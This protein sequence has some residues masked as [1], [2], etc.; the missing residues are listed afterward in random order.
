MTTTIPTER[1]DFASG[2]VRCAAWLTLPPGGGPHP[3]VVLIHGLGAT[4]DMALARYEQHFAAAGIATLAFDYRNTGLSD[5]VTRQH[6]SARDQ[7]ADVAAALT[8]LHER[9]DIDGTRIGLWGTSLGAMHA[10]RVAA[11]RDDVAATV[12]QCPIVHGPGAARRL[13]VLAALRLTPAIVDDVVRRATRRGRRYVP[14]VGPPGG[15][16]MVTVA[17]AEAGWQSTVDPGGHFD[18]RIGAADALG[19]VA[20]SSVRHARRIGAPL[21]VCVCDRE[22]LMDPRYAERVASR[23]P[24]GETRHYESDHFQIYHPPL[25]EHALADQTAFFQEHLRVRA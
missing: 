17:G 12:V 4:H 8:H 6:V 21:L 1:A 19:I 7:R 9:A 16:A 20:T 14:I 5:G 18:N 2:G 11:D 15:F 13:G 22:T 10:V 25:L 3:A 23:A 24:R